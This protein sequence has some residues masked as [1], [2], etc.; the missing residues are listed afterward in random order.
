[1]ADVSVTPGGSDRWSIRAFLR[2]RCSSAARGTGRCQRQ[3]FEQLQIS[4][5]ILHLR[6]VCKLSCELVKIFS[7]SASTLTVVAIPTRIDTRL[8]SSAFRNVEYLN[9][10]G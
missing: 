8:A 9:S 4:K 10:L 7:L 6:H 5:K 3:I 2:A 1:M